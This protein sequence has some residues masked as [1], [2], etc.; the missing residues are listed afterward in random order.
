MKAV[1]SFLF[2]WRKY[3]IHDGVKLGVGK[4]QS[5]KCCVGQ[6]KSDG[7]KKKVTENVVFFYNGK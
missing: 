5:T 6:S 2:V 1:L 4:T 3:I 7:Y